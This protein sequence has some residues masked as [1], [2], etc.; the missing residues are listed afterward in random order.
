MPRISTQKGKVKLILL[1]SLP[2][3]SL[4]SFQ[5]LISYENHPIY[6]AIT[7]TK[8]KLSQCFDE[9]ITKPVYLCA[10]VLDPRSKDKDVSS[11]ADHR[12]G[13]F[14][15]GDW[16]ELF[17]KEA[18][19]FVTSVEKNNIPDPVTQPKED[20][21]QLFKTACKKQLLEGR[22]VSY[23]AEPCDPGTHDALDYWNLHLTD[24]PL[25]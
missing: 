14:S 2:R 1:L 12:A 21:P 20:R 22:I 13:I 11:K 9:A 18:C 15:Q 10:Y 16:Q 8:T 5:A 7:L 6:P 23:I 24:Y 4:F 25:L 3:W 17:V 19:Q